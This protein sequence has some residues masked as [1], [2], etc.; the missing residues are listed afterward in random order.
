[1]TLFY[2]DS[3]RKDTMI[4]C[5]CSIYISIELISN[6]LLL[7]LTI[8]NGE[9]FEHRQENFHNKATGMFLT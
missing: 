8:S 9:I 5:K 4:V 1:M 6:E 3:P 2:V 7:L